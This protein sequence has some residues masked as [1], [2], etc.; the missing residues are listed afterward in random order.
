MNDLTTHPCNL[1]LAQSYDPFA[2]RSSDNDSIISGDVLMDEIGTIWRCHRMERFLA[3]L[4]VNNAA[5]RRCLL[6]GMSHSFRDIAQI[7]YF[8]RYLNGIQ[9]TR[10]ELSQFQSF[11]QNMVYKNEKFSQID[12]K[13]NVKIDRRRHIPYHKM[14][15]I[16]DMEYR[17]SHLDGLSIDPNI[18]PNLPKTEHALSH[19]IF[20]PLMQFCTA[21]GM[22]R[23]R[24]AI[25]DLEAQ[26]SKRF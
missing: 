2:K 9:G 20:F 18:A 25:R 11:C 15:H 19:V 8:I 1:T 17:K 12:E 23:W 7:W 16:Y 4:R 5:F 24:I 10:I 26:N 6:A 21:K 14:P 3:H 22:R 13:H